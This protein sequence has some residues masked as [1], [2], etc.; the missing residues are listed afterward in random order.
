ML[1]SFTKIILSFAVM[2]FIAA[3][4]VAADTQENFA[5]S[6]A[7][8]KRGQVPFASQQEKADAA[9]D[10]YEAEKFESIEPAAGADDYVAPAGKAQD[11]TNLAEQMRLPRK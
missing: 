5:P 6:Y 3:P 10:A 11:T 4:A 7:A 1:M 2:A 8:K 9:M